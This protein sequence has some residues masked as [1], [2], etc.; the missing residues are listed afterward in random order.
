M[1]ERRVTV[2]CCIGLRMMQD[3]LEQ[4]S[5]FRVSQKRMVDLLTGGVWFQ[6]FL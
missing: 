5:V 4:D 6:N 3:E 1:G 2:L